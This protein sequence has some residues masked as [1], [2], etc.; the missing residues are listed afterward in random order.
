MSNEDLNKKRFINDSLKVLVELA[1]ETKK[2]F[3]L[4]MGSVFAKLGVLDPTVA[5]EANQSP[6][7]IA[8]LAIQFPNLLCEPK[9]SELNYQWRSFRLYANNLAIENENIQKYWFSLS[10][11]KDV[12]GNSKFSL[13][14]SSMCTLTVLRI[15]RRVLR[16]VYIK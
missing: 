16:D 3:S 4:N 6:S 2:R 10:N 13:L 9:L 7:T 5:R 15:L 1:S 11:I 8:T 14:S 12:L